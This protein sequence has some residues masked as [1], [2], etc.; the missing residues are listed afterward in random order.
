MQLSANDT[1]DTENMKEQKKVNTSLNRW[2]R[3]CIK[4]LRDGRSWLNT[5]H[6]PP[7]DLPCKIKDGRWGE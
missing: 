4:V 7:I 3:L 2:K 5:S 1:K 6:K